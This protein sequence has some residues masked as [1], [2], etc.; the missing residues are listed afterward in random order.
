MVNFADALN[1][2]LEDIERPPLLPAGT[3]VWRITKSEQGEVTG[4]DGTEYATLNFFCSCVAPQAVDEEALAEFGNPVG[5]PN[6]VSFMF[7]TADAAKF[8]NTEY[9]LRTFLGDHLGVDMT[10]TLKEAIAAATN[11]QFL[12][13]IKWEPSRNNPDETYANISRTAPVD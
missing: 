10:M 3:Y 13:E 6:R 4:K 12:G 8:K 1:T 2:K 5:A 11:Q 9:R 7:N